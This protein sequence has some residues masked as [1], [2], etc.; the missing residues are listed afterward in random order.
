MLW[1]KLVYSNIS[2]ISLKLFQR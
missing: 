2:E 1:I